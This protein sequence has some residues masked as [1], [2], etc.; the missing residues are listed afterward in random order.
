[1]K[2][3]KYMAFI[4][5]AMFVLLVVGAWPAA[6]TIT[7]S[8][9]DMSVG[10][11]NRVV[12]LEDQICRACHVPHNARSAEALWSRSMGA[13]PYTPYGPGLDLD[14]TVPVPA[15]TSLLCLACHDGT[16]DLGDYV[17]SPT[18]G[19]GPLTGDVA[20]SADLSD[21]H[22][23]SF[24][25]AE[26]ATPIDLEIAAD[27]TA[28][29]GQTIADFLEDG[30]TMQCATCHDVHNSDSEVGGNPSLLRETSV[31]SAICL[32]CHLK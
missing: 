14:A 3:T 26:S 27:T 2:S 12:A 30:T 13:G 31:G 19:E 8:V 17:N 25:Y 9:H 28:F 4:A 5:M 32:T 1:M 11:G 29:G 22:P 21:D 15:G 23:I 24:L 16:L 10:S 6:A 7:D 20:L 18:P